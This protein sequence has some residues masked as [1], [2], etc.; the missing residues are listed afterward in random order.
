MISSAV[1]SSIA[2]GVPA[3]RLR[4]R[5]AFEILQSDEG[6]PASLADLEDPDDVRVIERANASASIVNRARFWGLPSRSSRIIFKAT[7]ALQL[8]LPRF[9]DNPHAASTQFLF[10]SESGHD[11]L[12]SHGSTDLAARRDPAAS[13]HDSVRSGSF[14]AVSVDGE[15]SGGDAAN[16]EGNRVA[17]VERELPRR[18]VRPARSIRC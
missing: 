9:I 8:N 5:T 18:S 10:D 12:V 13:F 1:A 14:H 3:A 7:I 11:F 17:K 15:L 4:E 6:H 2:C 16:A